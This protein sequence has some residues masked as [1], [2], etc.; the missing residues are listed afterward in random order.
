[1]AQVLSPPHAAGREAEAYVLERYRRVLWV[2]LVVNASMFIVEL[3]AGWQGH[4]LSLLADALDFFGDAVNYGASLLALS[5]GALWRSRTA[6]A[7]GLVMSAY[8]LAVLA[9]AGW[10]L[11]HGAS[12]HAAVMGLVATL[13]LVAN[14]VVAALLFRHRHG[15]ADMRSVWLCSRNDALG[16]LAVLLAAAAVSATGSSWPDLLVAAG[17]A[18]LALVSGGSVISQSRRE[19]GQ[20]RAAPPS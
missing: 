6:L 19:I 15:D 1:M 4:S 10:S 11:A 2:A 20:L 3:C 7:K 12:P 8:G 17:M 16:N 13:A 5:F 9:R 18:L 14:I